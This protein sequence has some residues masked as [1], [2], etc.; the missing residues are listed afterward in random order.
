MLNPERP[1]TNDER[2]SLAA[3]SGIFA[4]VD[5][6]YIPLRR[7]ENDYLIDRDTQRTQSYTGIRGISEQDAAIADSQGVIA[8]RTNEMLV[9]TDLGVVRF[10]QTM[11][12]ATTS[13]ASGSEPLGVDRP[14][15]YFVRSG[16]AVAASESKLEEVVSAR[17][18]R[19]GGYPL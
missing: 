2:R 14:D 18:G 17:F 7:R 19:M 4:E 9:Q 10:R 12:E 15:A 16:D 6:H 5:D 3:G 1:L 8:D 13:V 11:F